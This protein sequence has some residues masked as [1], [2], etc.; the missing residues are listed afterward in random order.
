MSNHGYKI[1]VVQFF[2][3]KKFLIVFNDQSEEIMR[4]PGKTED[5]NHGGQDP[6]GSSL[7]GDD[8]RPLLVLVALAWVII[9][10]MGFYWSAV[11]F[12]TREGFPLRA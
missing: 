5:Q 10:K 4:E 12:L 2:R 6:G 3:D 1:S 9:L 11:T 7:L 8:T